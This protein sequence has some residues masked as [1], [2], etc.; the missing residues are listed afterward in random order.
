MPHRRDSARLHAISDLLDIPYSAIPR[1]SNGLPTLDTASPGQQRFQ[2]ALFTCLMS[3]SRGRHVWEHPTKTAMASV[4]SYL[5]CIIPHA[6]RVDLHTNT[7]CRVASRLMPLLHPGSRVSGIPGLRLIEYGKQRLRFCHL[8]TGARLDLVDSHGCSTRRGMGSDLRRET[9]WHHE[10]AQQPLGELAE[11]TPEEETHQQHWAS[12]P[13]T[14]LRSSLLV[15]AIWLYWE[16]NPVWKPAPPG[17]GYGQLL[18]RD[19]SPQAAVDLV[20]SSEARIPGATFQ[21][22]SDDEGVLAL[23]D[24]GI[25]L[26]RTGT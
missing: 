18:Y 7:A 21:P 26:R 5:N 12:A 25:V 6:D 1:T 9:R 15:R 10:D 14:A 4:C 8:P 17:G 13:C 3:R 22:R 19:A 11:V 23:G 20:T 2:A 16:L 24:A